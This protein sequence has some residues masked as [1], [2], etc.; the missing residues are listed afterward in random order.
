[1]VFRGVRAL[2]TSAR[3]LRASRV[4]ALDFQLGTKDAVHRARLGALEQLLPT[5]KGR[6]GAVAFAV[7]QAL[8][9]GWLTESEADV[10]RFESAQAMYYPTWVRALLTQVVDGVWKVRC[11]G[12]T[13]HA[14]ATC[15]YSAAHAVVSTNSAFPGNAWKPMDT[16]PL[17]A[18]PALTP[19]L[20]QAPVPVVK[21]AEAPMPYAPFDRARHLHPAVDIDGS[22]SVLPFNISPRALPDML[23][24]AD[25]RT[26]MVDMLAEGPPLHIRRRFKVLP[27]VEIQVA[28]V[29]EQPDADAQAI[30]RL[31]RDSLEVD[32]LASY[33]VL[34]PIHLVRFR[35]DAHGETDRLATVAVGAWDERLLAYAL[36]CDEQPNWVAKGAPS[37]LNID[38]LDFDP[39]VP[40]A[41]SVLDPN[42]GQEAEHSEARIVDLMTQQSQMQSIFEGRAEELIDAA[43]WAPC[44]AWDAARATPDAPEAHAGL[45]AIEWDARGVRPLYEGVLENRQYI[46]L[47]GEA[48][49]SERLLASVEHDEREGR[50]ISN[51]HTV[52]EGRLVAGQEAVAALRARLA[53]VHAQR[54]ASR[55]AWMDQN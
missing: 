15:T 31:E 3:A 25:L 54:A 30:V 28:N 35:Y 34:L 43:D 27:G 48:L 6:W 44:R 9:F 45:G 37:W 13:G 46:A 40:V 7:S 2:S 17:H 36:Y 1:M 4:S 14:M 22:I 12:D 47:T 50:D 8:G 42:A 16:L 49:F 29:N 55:P 20:E 33:P 5:I 19:E 51:V 38:M 32:V 11:R 53:E 39:H 18:P 52:H 26:L 23:R 10:M 21:D 24:H 41:Q